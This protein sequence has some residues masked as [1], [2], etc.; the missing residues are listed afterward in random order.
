MKSC[1]PFRNLFLQAWGGVKRIPY[2][3]KACQ[4]TAERSLHTEDRAT[5]DAA[6]G[7]LI[8]QNFYGRTVSEVEECR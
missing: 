4:V 1:V 3:Y 8:T 5:A 2:P 7:I 6:S